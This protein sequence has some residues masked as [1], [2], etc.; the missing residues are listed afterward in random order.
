MYVKKFAGNAGKLKRGLTGLLT[1]CLV[2]TGIPMP[3]AAAANE[4]LEEQ[5]RPDEAKTAAPEDISISENS[6][7]DGETDRT[8]E[9]AA[10]NISDIAKTD[11][12]ENSSGGES[13]DDGE[14][15]SD[16]RMLNSDYSVQVSGNDALENAVL[17][18]SISE[19]DISDNDI[20]GNDLLQYAENVEGSRIVGGYIELPEDKDISVVDSEISL[21]AEDALPESYIPKPGT[22]PLT[23]NQDPYGSCWAHTA[24][25]LAEID[26]MRNADAVSS[27]DFSELHLAYFSYSGTVEDPL[28]G[29]EG[30]ANTC[31]GGNFLDRGG[32]LN[33]AKNV[34]ASWVGAADENTAPYSQA[35]EALEN[36]LPAELAFVDAVHLQN[37]YNVNL[38]ENPEIAKQMILDYGGLGASYYDGLSCYNSDNNCYYNDKA[39][40]TNHAI[41]IVGWD[42]AFLASNFTKTPEKDGAWLIRNSWS[43]GADADSRDHHTYFWMSYYDKTLTGGYVFDFEPA[44]TYQHN[45][46][47]D[48]AM[49]TGATVITTTK[50]S[51]RTANVFTAQAH[52]GGELLKAVGIGIYR[53]QT[54]YTVSIY[55]NPTDP[56]DPESGELIEEAGTS[57]VSHCEGFYTVEL[58]SPV[59]LAKGDTFAVVVDIGAPEGST[60][61]KVYLAKEAAADNWYQCTTAAKAGQSFYI[62]NGSWKDYGADKNANLRIKAYTV[63]DDGPEFPSKIQLKEKLENGIDVGVGDTFQASCSVRPRNAKNRSI[64]WES[65]DPSIAAIGENGLI[66]GISAGTTTITASCAAD[67]SINASFPVE[68]FSELRYMTIEGADSVAAGAAA[69]MRTVRRP[70]NAEDLVQW[71]SSD[72]RVLTVDEA[73]LVTGVAPGYAL[74]TASAGTVSASKELTCELPDFTW[75]YTASADGLRIQWPGA[76]N[77]KAY[78]VYRAVGSNNWANAKMLKEIESDGVHTY[79]YLDQDVEGGKEYVYEIE[80][81]VNYIK[82]DSTEEKTKRTGRYKCTMPYYYPITY[83]LDGGTND[84]GNPAVYRAGQAVYLYGGA[85]KAGYTF[86]G[87][88][89]DEALTQEIEKSST[90]PTIAVIPADHTGA[91]DVFA[92]WD[93]IPK[94]I[95]YEPDGGENSPDNPLTYISSEG[96]VTLKEAVKEGYDFQGWYTESAFQNRIDSLDSSLAGDIRLYAKWQPHTYT[97]TYE[98]AGGIHEN[99]AAYTVETPDFTLQDAVKEWYPFEGWYTDPAYQVQV[100]TIPA[101][102]MG[103]MLL[104]AKWGKE[105]TL[106]NAE[107]SLSSGSFTYTGAEQTPQAAI[108]FD[109]TVLEENQDYILSYADN[110]N[111]G[112][113]AATAKGIGSYS[114]S[115]SKS[116][117]IE[118]AVVRIKAKDKTIQTRDDV[119][120]EGAYEYEASG[121]L[122][123]DQLLI[124]PKFTCGIIDTAKAGQYT[125]MPSGADAGPNYTVQYEEGLLT[126]SARP[127]SY[128]VVFD[129]MDDSV[130]YYTGKA[131]K[132]AV[133]I[134][135]KDTLLKAGKDYTIQYFNNID[136]NQGSVLTAGSGQGDDFNS[137]LPYVQI[138]G[139]GNYDDEI[140]VNFD[141]LPIAIGDGSGAPAKQFTFAYTD[142]FVFS[143]KPLKP[144]KSIKHGKSM[145]QGRD[146]ALSL[147]A[148]D[149]S[150]SL[151]NAVQKDTVFDDAVIPAE[152]GGE[153]LLTV[154]GIGNYTG[155][156]NRKIYVANKWHLMKNA[157]ITLGK[158]QKNREWAGGMAELTPSLVDSP[159]TFTVKIGADVLKPEEDYTVSYHN[160]DRAGKAELTIT[161]IGEYFGTKTVAFNVKGKPFTAKTILITGVI[162]QSYTGGAITQETAVLVYG[163][164]TAEKRIL[165]EGTDYTVSY[166][167]NINKGTAAVTFTGSANAGFIGSFKKSFKITA[168]SIADAARGDGMDAISVSYSSLGARPVEE[169]VLTNAMGIRLQNGK[170]YTLSYKNNRAVAKSTDQ[171]APTVTVKGRGN[172]QG[173]FDIPFTITK[174]DL[175]SKLENRDIIMKPTAVAYQKNKAGSYAYTPVIKLMEGKK[176]LRA[177]TDYEITYLNNTQADYEAYMLNRAE[178]STDSSLQMPK[179]VITVT[180]DSN[181]MI[182]ETDDGSGIEIPL[183]VYQNKLTKS[184]LHVNV[185]E[186][187]YTG[188]QVKPDVA[189][190]YQ[191]E[192][193]LHTLTENRDYTVS[194]GANIRSGKKAGSVTIS[195]LGPYYGGNVTVKFEIQKKNINTE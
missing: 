11:D 121:L 79:F 163:A 96:S 35:E 172:Y 145:K 85:V 51:V 130:C 159:D 59:E 117:T 149:A 104:Y 132:P 80:A 6:V 90:N 9:N 21:F 107:M 129:E 65:A 123:K 10:E 78:R 141:I 41:T 39:A 164:G 47:Y 27:V 166:S 184:N 188:N 102:S 45:Y 140:K 31:T 122:A 118:P 37:Y 54:P 195:G 185:Q 168:R 42:D 174:A 178:E 156:I 146:Y 4:V 32:N 183:P 76:E 108:I 181:Y 170:D 113:A 58:E 111:A 60:D 14:N 57:G 5:S 142:Q 75:R 173:S 68:I 115:I 30:D 136:A 62:M 24:M 83:H 64:L 193:G 73:G 23:R 99:P 175:R 162:D 101:G 8:G 155:S 26:M 61:N 126:V 82:G 158:N 165:Q 55:V 86:A 177:G 91:V 95:T 72:E 103:D 194:Y 29:L 71:S 187:V 94:K 143:S 109:G 137:S 160:N 28:G 53:A 152:Y 110:V 56:A 128:R 151:G 186:A 7:T 46:Q 157:K 182:S 116:F 144:F 131:W 13:P 81:V 106:A 98:T 70:A 36:G 171:N 135:D 138:T 89:Y 2:L 20:S 25:A 167:K 22:L 44:D 119:P 176:P 1:A 133:S 16:D 125:I 12:I 191:D 147:T 114:G 63:D 97:I 93:E 105:R 49:Q 67:P 18:N 92:K 192:T 87:W 74:V 148:V 124:P 154:T 43:A 50:R 127:A 84:S 3:A 189:V 34:L 179:A 112:T 77:V 190:A 17:E 52:E 66:T 69:N 48:G 180:A 161:G 153:F 40:A 15:V 150:D 38:Q 100:T 88:Y 134:Y 120:D 139:K 169:I 19:N 33:L